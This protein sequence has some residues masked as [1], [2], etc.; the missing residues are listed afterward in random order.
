MPEEIILSPFVADS[1]F[2]LVTADFKAKTAKEVLHFMEVQPSFERTYIIVTATHRERVRNFINRISCKKGLPI[3][4]YVFDSQ[5]DSYHIEC[6]DYLHLGYVPISF[7]TKIK[8][9]DHWETRVPMP[10]NVLRK[11]LNSLQKKELRNFKN[12]FK[13]EDYEVQYVQMIDPN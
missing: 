10:E 5:T 13:A 7:V 8:G 4:G 9:L 2:V 11:Y 6:A 12:H 1:D 3:G